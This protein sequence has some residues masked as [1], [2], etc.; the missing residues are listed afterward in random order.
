MI[1][2]VKDWVSRCSGVKLS[3]LGFGS[4]G[5]RGGNSCGV[6]SLGNYR[7]LAMRPLHEAV[8]VGCVSRPTSKDTGARH[9]H[10][11]ATH[12]WSTQ[13]CRQNQNLFTFH[14]KTKF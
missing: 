4:C 9:A 12:Q 14:S 1:I 8:G 7:M 6:E 13:Q 5:K 3:L 2:T 10:A 11:S